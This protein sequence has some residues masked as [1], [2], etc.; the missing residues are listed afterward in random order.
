MVTLKL[1]MVYGIPLEILRYLYEGEIDSSVGMCDSHFC[2]ETERYY[3]PVVS[4]SL[5]SDEK[6]LREIEN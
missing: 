5:E 4:V 2:D 1:I 6:L 3:S